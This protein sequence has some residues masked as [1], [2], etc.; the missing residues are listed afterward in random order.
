M[1]QADKGHAALRRGR[2]SLNDASYFL[3]FCTD[4]RAVG[5]ATGVVVAAIL[6]EAKE[7]SL[8]W[9]LRSAVVMPDH[10]HLIVDLAAGKTLPEVVRSFK[11]RSSVLLRDRGL[12]WQR[13]YYDHRLRTAED[14]LPVFLYVFLNPYRAGLCKT[15]GTWAGYY[16]APD[17]WEWFGSLTHSECPFP[18]WLQ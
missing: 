3:T 4:R 8:G 6:R 13:G 10:A 9:R 1:H 18:E 15:D 11:G 14:L 17:D 7:S 16:C 5:L 2:V 12:K